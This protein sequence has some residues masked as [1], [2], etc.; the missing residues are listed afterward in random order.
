MKRI[1]IIALVGLLALSGCSMFNWDMNHQESIRKGPGAQA[2]GAAAYVEYGPDGKI[3]AK[4][5]KF[6]DQDGKEY[7]AEAEVRKDVNSS[8]KSW[9]SD[10]DL[11]RFGSQKELKVEANINKKGEI[12]TTTD[13]EPHGL[14]LLEWLLIGAAVIIGPVLLGGIATAVGFPA[15]G[16]ILTMI[17]PISWLGKLGNLIPKK[18]EPAVEET[19]ETEENENA[20]DS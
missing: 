15:I 10:F 2:K 3:V 20:S 6:V 19:P 12:N 7:P 16:A 17:S 8:S 13:Q 14:T 5:D 9:A 1:T 18:T 11:L 4:A